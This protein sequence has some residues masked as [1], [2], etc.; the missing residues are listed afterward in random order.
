MAMRTLSGS[1]FDAMPTARGGV[2]IARMISE[3]GPHPS[4][5]KPP[6]KFFSRAQKEAFS[7]F[8]CVASFRAA[9]VSF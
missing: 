6:K 9:F 7:A 8:C 5:P 4:F 1:Q 3:K 2:K